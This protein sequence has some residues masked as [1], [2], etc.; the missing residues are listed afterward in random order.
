M[1]KEKNVTESLVTLMSFVRE[2]ANASL[3]EQGRRS[4]IS[5]DNLRKLSTV[6]EA[7]ITNAFMRGMDSILKEVKKD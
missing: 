3:V 1:T 2:Q 4:D 7:S 5:E 6:I